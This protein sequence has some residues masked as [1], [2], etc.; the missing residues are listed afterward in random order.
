MLLYSH[1][2]KWI[3]ILFLTLCNIAANAQTSFDL[4][5][6]SVINSPSHSAEQFVKPAEIPVSYYTGTPQINF[7]LFQIRSG[8]L[9]HDV[10]LNYNA[11]GIM[12]EEEAGWLGL[13]WDLSVG[14]TIARSIVGRN[15]EATTSS[16][17][18]QAATILNMPLYNATNPETW[19]N[20]L[21]HANQKQISDGIY[22]LQPDTYFLNFDGQSAKLF[23]DKNGNPYIS[24]Y[25]PWKITGNISTGFT[26]TNEAGTIYQFTTVENSLYDSYSSANDNS[27]TMSANSAL[28]LSRII[29]ANKTDTIQ[30]NYLPV[31]FTQSSKTQSETMYN[32]TDGQNTHPCGT[33]LAETT[34]HFYS[35]TS[36]TINTYYLSSITYRGGKVELVVT[37]D[38]LDI[39]QNNQ[40]N[41]YRVR[42]LNVYS[43]NNGA[44]TLVKKI[45]FYQDYFNNAASTSMAKRLMLTK[46]TLYSATDSM[47]H[48]FSY[49]TPN[50]L[51]NKNSLAQDHWGYYNGREASTLIPAYD[52]HLGTTYTGADRSPDSN[53]VT[54]GM[55]H[56]ITYP[57]GG[58]ATL[59]YEINDYSFIKSSPVY[60]PAHKDSSVVQ[61]T[62][63]ATT[64]HVTTNAGQDTLKIRLKL[65]GYNMSYFITG[66]IPSDPLAEVYIKDTLGNTLFA[67][68]T[69]NG[70]TLPIT[71]VTLQTNKT[72][73]L[74][75]SRDKSTERA[76]IS[77]QYND[78][79]YSNKPTLFKSLAGGCRI[80]R[81]TKYDGI[82]HAND[83][84]SRFV[85]QLNDSTSSGILSNLPIYEGLQYTPYYCDNVKE[86]N[87]A[88]FTRHAS[89]LTALGKTQGS[90]IG[91]SKVTM[92]QGE[93]GENGRQEFFY[94]ISGL[95]DEGGSGYP[96]IPYSSWDDLRG[97]QLQERTYDAQGRILQARVNN[98]D[99]NNQLG[100]NN[101]KWVFGAKYGT[102]RSSNV[103]TNNDPAPPDWQFV[104]GMY[105]VYQFW[106]ILLSTTDSIFNLSGGYMTK[107]T[108][109]TYDSTNL[110][111]SSE[112]FT[113]SNGDQVVTTY[114]YPDNFA[115]TPVYDSMRA[116]NMITSVIQK[117]VT[118][119]AVQASSQKNNFALFGSLV[120]PAGVDA[121]AGS[122]SLQN[123]SLF[124]NYDSYG[125]LLAQGKT[126]DAQTVYLW[127]YNYQYPVA[128]IIGSTYTA[129][130]ALVSNSILQNPT[131]AQQLRDELNKIRTALAGSVAQVFTYT[132][133]P[134]VG[135]TSETNP[136][137][138]TIFYEYDDLNRIVRLKDANGMII[139]QFDY[140]Y[141]T[142]ITQ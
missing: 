38:R 33:V 117:T 32:L 122:G 135:M 96:Y 55:L 20:T 82:N 107:K 72:Y 124:Y 48:A 44:Y 21:T 88:Y 40:G 15:D 78:W 132:Y 136:A 93:N 30:F 103:I 65:S 131:S 102:S 85:Y 14:G 22:D 52:D 7:P 130:A 142:S 118:R 94:T 2:R 16:G 76:V 23:F 112:T 92:L 109:F 18:T 49:S 41:Q 69:S 129:V 67:A 115:G 133:A 97:M 126:D 34:K 113:A 13:G 108:S 46:F 10:S 61:V 77:I 42:E 28:Y 64:V 50:A 24:P 4:T 17:Y 79:S 1:Y 27:T 141:Q 56:S 47:T 39:D 127:G 25:R 43:Q 5:G 134:Q 138:I 57:S 116:R 101:F 128:R 91:Y 58:V 31:S 110:K 84:V 36:Q 66:Q 60:A 70:T 89:S 98:Y 53:Y 62:Q 19:L 95:N 90:T 11:N 83:K 114:K 12:V 125:N 123:R 80:K 29:S 99:Y 37:Q 137:G 73:Y 35:Y 87:W 6:P 9:T 111:V 54:N 86:G 81:I 63:S 68:G 120:L 100:D 75:A 139:K 140:N 119:N 121:V 26:V 59:D 71:N 105:K 3:L 106:P 51:P 104:G 8:A 45:K 74:I